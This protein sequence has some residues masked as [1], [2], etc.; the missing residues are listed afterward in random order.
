MPTHSFFGLHAE[1]ACVLHRKFQH[2][3]PEDI[4]HDIIRGALWV[5]RF[6]ITE[7]LS[8]LTR[9][10]E[11]VVNRLLPALGHSR[12]SSLPFKT[13]Q[14]YLRKSVSEYQKDG[15]SVASSW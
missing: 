9:Y 7:A 2:R 8:W 15:V 12:L 4:A 11:F 3:L 6:F 14:I 10:I 1:F 5:E 13:K